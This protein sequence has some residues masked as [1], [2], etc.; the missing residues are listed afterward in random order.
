MN[1]LISSQT[2]RESF[3][4][5]IAWGD[6][7]NRNSFYEPHLVLQNTSESIGEE[8]AGKIGAESPQTPFPPRLHFGAGIWKKSE[9]RSSCFAKSS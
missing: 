2:N 5:M 3:A 8:E 1:P 6:E 4:A 9:R 7:E